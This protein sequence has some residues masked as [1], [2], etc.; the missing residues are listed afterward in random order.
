MAGKA[1][2][3]FYLR[4]ALAEEPPVACDERVIAA[5]GMAAHARRVRRTRIGWFASAACLFVALGCGWL[6]RYDL[7]REA[8]LQAEGELMLEITGMA[9]YEEFYC[10]S[11]ADT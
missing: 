7:E 3:E 9:S 11:W 1:D 4:D 6:W 8:R 5:I 2:M 10:E